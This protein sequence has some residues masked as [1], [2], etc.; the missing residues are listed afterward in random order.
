MYQ[1]VPNEMLQL[2][3]NLNGNWV[4]NYKV[5][6]L[7]LWQGVLNN[8][9][10]TLCLINKQI[11]NFGFVRCEMSVRQNAACAPPFVMFVESCSA[12]LI[13]L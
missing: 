8:S 11:H 1:I 4:A 6:R 7:Q 12:F 5:A 10:E 9:N 2:W 13:Q 3:A